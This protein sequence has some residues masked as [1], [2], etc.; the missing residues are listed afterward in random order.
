MWG[1]YNYLLRKREEGK[2]K[3]WE[4]GMLQRIENFI[5][6]ERK[7]VEAELAEKRRQQEGGEG[8]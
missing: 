2:I 1:Q 3:E 4:I 7:K 6:K 5:K 8:Q